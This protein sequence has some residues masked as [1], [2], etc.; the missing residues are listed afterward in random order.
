M[1]SSDWLKQYYSRIIEEYKFSMGR[2]DRVLDWSIGIF[3]VA[4]VAY[5]ELLRYE[6]PSIWRICLIVGLLCFIMR[7]FSSSCLA[8]A[9]LKKWRYLL[10][11]IEKHWKSNT[12]SLDSLKNEIEKYHYTPRTT[13]KRTYFISHQLVGGFFLLFLV[14]FFLL[15]FEIYSNPQDL[16]IIIP[17][18][19]LAVYCIYESI[20]YITNKERSMPSENTLPPVSNEMGRVVK[21]E[22][23]NR[24]NLATFVIGVLIGVIGN[25]LVSS[26]IEYQKATNF[27]DRTTWGV[28]AAVSV[29]L[30]FHILQISG[31]LLT[32]PKG[33]IRQFRILKYLSVLLVA[34]VW[35]LE[36]FIIPTLLSFF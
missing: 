5:V 3:F 14:P 7:L 36:F 13:E 24:Q 27:L 10:D 26:V 34:F 35:A 25:F 18:S 19:F 31:R 8:Y 2:K 9:Y 21:T 17:V 22:E 16:N 33:L 28:L 6:L 11:L 30:F 4:L 29:A 32:M 20:I 23:Q 15:L 1:S 12:V